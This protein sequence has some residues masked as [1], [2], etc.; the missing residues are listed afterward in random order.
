MQARCIKCKGRGFCGRHSCPIYTKQTAQFNVRKRLPE[1]SFT[2]ASPAPFIGRYGYPNVN[3][4]VLAPSEKE[5]K[6]WEYDAPRHWAQK[7]YSIPDIVGFR[8]SLINSSEKLDVKDQGRFHEICKEVAIARKPVD[9]ELDIKRRPT[10]SVRLDSHAPPVG[11]RAEL[12]KAQITE[13]PKVNRHLE[14]AV[15]DTDQSSASA[16]TELYSKGVDEN[17]L[18]K[19]L[20]VGALGL[21]NRRKMVPTRWSITAVDDQLGKD[22]LERVKENR[23]LDCTA[24]FGGYL[25]NYYLILMFPDIWS[26][27]LFEAY[28]PKASWNQGDT[29]DFSTDHEP[30]AGRKGYAENCAGGYYAARLPII[31][32]LRNMKRQASVLAIRIITGEYTTPLGVWV[33]REAAKK[34]LQQRPIGFADED[35]MLNYARI[36]VKKRFG[37]DIGEILS[38]SVLLKE[39]KAQAKLT[40]FIKTNK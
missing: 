5:E 3:V 36:L 21:R 30:F 33:C 28:M 39:K 38:K 18:S 22:I 37:Y 10:F 13:N 2:S 25:G 6:A 4:G 32:K 8:S 11:P 16:M 1:R 15:D 27:E 31:E 29:V 7:G 20:S 35:L 26:Y 23:T 24:F 12:E 34:A 40:G 19:V 14:K 17:Q 9:V